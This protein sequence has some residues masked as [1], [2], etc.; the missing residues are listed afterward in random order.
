VEL[1]LPP[2]S[3]VEDVIDEQGNPMPVPQDDWPLPTGPYKP[4]PKTGEDPDP[5]NPRKEV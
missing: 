5:T 3:S 2:E 4:S 1:R